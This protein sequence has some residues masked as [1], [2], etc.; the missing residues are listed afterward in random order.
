MAETATDPNQG[1]RF[2][3]DLPVRTEWA[4]VDLLRGSIQ[5]CF[6]AVF[7]DLEECERLA[8]VTGELLENAVKYGSWTFDGGEKPASFRL[9]VYGVGV[10]ASIRVEN[11]INPT[12][13]GVQ[14]LFDTLKWIDSFEDT[15]A[16]YRARLLDLAQGESEGGATRLGL[17]RVAHEGSCHLRAEIDGNTLAVIADFNI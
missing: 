2:T 14:A 11:P 16:M 17:M 13:P 15:G 9:Y 4:S 6:S 5:T 7:G 8:M 10:K 1:Y 3:I 12:D